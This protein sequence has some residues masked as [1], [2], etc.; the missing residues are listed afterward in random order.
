MPGFKLFELPLFA[1]ASLL[2]LDTVGITNEDMSDIVTWVSM[3]L[4]DSFT[5]IKPSNINTVVIGGKGFV[6]DILSGNQIA[7]MTQRVIVDQAVSSRAINK[8]SF[9]NIGIPI[10]LKT[11]LAGL[12]EENFPL[13]R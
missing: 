3:G 2:V 13:L 5:L 4:V 10:L 8:L 1:S 6:A 12:F 7:S 9:N 11:E